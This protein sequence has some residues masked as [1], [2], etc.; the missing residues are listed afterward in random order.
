M[1]AQINPVVPTYEN[2]I[3]PL[4]NKLE[5]QKRKAAAADENKD[6]LH[7]SVHGFQKQEVTEM[8]KDYQALTKCQQ[9][10]VEHATNHPEEACEY[11]FHKMCI[12]IL[13]LFLSTNS[14][15]VNQLIC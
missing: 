2:K 13:L 10:V 9:K 14:F 4:L 6:K 5:Y 11:F 7:K 15:V 3:N 12:A 1:F 8:E